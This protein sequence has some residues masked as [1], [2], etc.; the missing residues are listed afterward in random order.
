ME[1]NNVTR[2]LNENFADYDY[3]ILKEL[4]DFAVSTNGAFTPFFEGLS[5]LFEKGIIL[6]VIAIIMCCFR[7]TRKIGICMFGAVCCGA[8][9]TNILLK[10]LIARPRPFVDVNNIYH[11][12]WQFV[13]SS[14]ETAFSFPSGHV[15][16][17][18]AAMTTIFAYC[19]KRYSWISFLLVIIMG[20]ARNY[21]MVHYPSDVLGGI[22]SGLISAIVAYNITEIIYYILEKY[23]KNRFFKFILEF[24]VLKLVSKK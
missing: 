23:Q 22:V 3:T 15:T 11:S 14:K 5:I 20:I 8:L 24:D 2:W 9:I 4:H 10:D 21:L 18:M 7:R 16:A 12:W 19:K 1:T 17:T 6:F 13:G